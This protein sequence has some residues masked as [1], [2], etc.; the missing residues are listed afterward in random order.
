MQ[1]NFVNWNYNILEKRKEKMENHS[2]QFWS[3]YKLTKEPSYYLFL[4]VIFVVCYHWHGTNFSLIIKE[5]DDTIIINLM[6]IIIVIIITIFCGLFLHL[7]I[8][9]VIIFFMNSF[10]YFIH[11][12]IE[13]KSFFFP[14]ISYIYD[15]HIIKCY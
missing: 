5:H 13:S 3:L 10:V 14:R 9:S 11:S 1:R 2:S 8:L 4:F 15:T 7:H 6:I 12:L